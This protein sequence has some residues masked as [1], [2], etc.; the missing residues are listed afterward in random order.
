MPVPSS[1]VHCLGSYTYDFLL[2]T[3]LDPPRKALGQKLGP[4]LLDLVC[5][6]SMHPI[7]NE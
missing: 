6:R 1:P 2:D 7:G 3:P 4:L 5:M